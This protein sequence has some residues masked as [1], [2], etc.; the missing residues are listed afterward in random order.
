MKKEEKLY[1]YDEYLKK[2]FPKSHKTQ[3]IDKTEQS[4]NFGYNLAIES[5]QKIKKILR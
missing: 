2:F 5:L 4:E 3:T 1:N